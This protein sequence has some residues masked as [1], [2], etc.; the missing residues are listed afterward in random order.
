MTEVLRGFIFLGSILLLWLL[1]SGSLACFS[2][3]GHVLWPNRTAVVGAALS[4]APARCF[5]LGTLNVVG[6]VVLIRIF[7]HF[8]PGG[9]LVMLLLVVALLW[10]LALGLPVLFNSIG[11]AVMRRCERKSTLAGDCFVGAY[12]LGGAALLPW[13]G[14][15]L[16]LFALLAA[17]GAGVTALFSRPA[18]AADPATPVP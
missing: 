8:G 4:G 18:P 16:F 9:R 11:A 15:A 14:W 13:L 17:V 2:L 5:L 3:L 10:L 7:A 6:I 1:A 12:V